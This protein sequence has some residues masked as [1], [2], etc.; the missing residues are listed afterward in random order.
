MNWDLSLKV[1]AWLDGEL[2]DPEARAVAGLLSTNPEAKALAEELRTTKTTLQNNEPEVK[3]PESREFYWSK[4]R[5]AIERLEESPRTAA[6]WT[7]WLSGLRRWLVPVAGVA[8][9]TVL[10]ISAF[11]V[12]QPPTDPNRYLTETENLSEHI[13]S[14]SF[15]APEQNL[16]VVWVYNRSAET[17]PDLLETEEW[18]Y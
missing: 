15:R 12:S 16:F 14:Y 5:R 6:P 9:V 13:G 4:L 2:P 7:D 3:L 8:L 11:R 17:S 18:Y 1:Q 10:A